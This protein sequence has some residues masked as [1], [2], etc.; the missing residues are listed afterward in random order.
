MSA[1]WWRRGENA[2][3]ST[4]Q[5]SNQSSAIGDSAKLLESIRPDD[6][7]EYRVLAEGPSVTLWINGQRMCQV[8]DHEERFALPRGV[9]ALQLHQGPPMKVE[10]KDLRIRVLK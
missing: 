4:R 2:F 3:A 6:W 7:N 5:A 9:I 10:F 8:E 1:A